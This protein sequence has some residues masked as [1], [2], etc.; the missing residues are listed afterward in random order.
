MSV[1]VV[2]SILPTVA[3]DAVPVG[4][5]NGVFTVPSGAHALICRVGIEGNESPDPINL[6]TWEATNLELLGITG[7]ESSTDA[8]TAVYGLLNP[9]V[10]TNGDVR[11]EVDVSAGPQVALWYCVSFSTGLPAS[12]RGAVKVISSVVNTLPT[13]NSQIANAG[14]A[15]RTLHVFGVHQDGT[16]AA[17]VSSPW[18]QL[19]EGQTANTDQDF[20]YMLAEAEG[21]TS[22]DIDWTAS[23][24]NTADVVE[25]VEPLNWMGQAHRMAIAGMPFPIQGLDNLQSRYATAGIPL[26]KPEG[27]GQLGATLAGFTADFDGTYAAPPPSEFD[28]SD[29]LGIHLIPDPALGFDYQTRLSIGGVPGV[30]ATIVDVDRDGVVSST[31]SAFTASFTGLNNPP[32]VDGDVLVTLAGVTTSFVGEH[33]YNHFFDVSYSLTPA[34]IF[35]ELPRRD[36]DLSATLAAFTADID[37]TS[38]PTDSTQGRIPAV[39][40]NVSFDFDGTFVVAP[41]RDGD[42]GL[43]I[44]NFS[45]LWQ[46]VALPDTG[47]NGLV[48]FSIENFA[49][50]LVGSFEKQSTDGF[51]Q[52]T[53]GTIAANFDGV[54]L[55]SGVLF[56]GFEPTLDNFILRMSGTSRGNPTGSGVASGLRQTRGVSS[57]LRSSTSL[58]SKL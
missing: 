13:A 5:M 29:R 37:G 43:S 45:A 7:L 50:D 49:S 41:G 27:G 33:Y 4:V 28:F 14:D 11:F 21:Q 23:D 9:A 39:L 25:F 17:T 47:T 26:A 10:V 20:R 42:V 22:V 34:W 19:A 24:E 58:G 15:G 52:F 40:E 31:M 44:Q 36:G 55:D 57:R 51:A 32:I 6:P 35:T 30:Q 53:L 38:L 54:Y 56:G 8:R 16:T 2:G 18:T 1:S 48:G 12:L 3:T 46:G